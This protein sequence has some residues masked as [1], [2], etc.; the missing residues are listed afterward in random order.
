ME[1]ATPGLA[2]AR[3][4]RGGAA[5]TGKGR[6]RG[7]PA[8]RADLA[9][10]IPRLGRAVSHPRRPSGHPTSGAGAPRAGLDRPPIEVHDGRVYVTTVIPVL[11]LPRGQE[12]DLAG[13]VERWPALCSPMPSR[14]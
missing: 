13:V 8:R 5:P 6:A 1:A 7:S 9:P 2:R 14:I 4:G 12:F 10:V 3:R 11:G